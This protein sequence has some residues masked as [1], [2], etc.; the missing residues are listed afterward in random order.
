MLDITTNRTWV[1]PSIRISY[2]PIKI[3][4]KNSKINNGI[5][6]YGDNIKCGKDVNP[7][8]QPGERCGGVLSNQTQHYAYKVVAQHIL[9]VCFYAQKLFQ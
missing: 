8:T 1:E 7:L 4:I 5:R 9:A 3:Y 6:F 2:Q